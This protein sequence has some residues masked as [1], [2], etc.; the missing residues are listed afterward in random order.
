MPQSR[1]RRYLKHGM[2]PQLR[3]FEA[4][5]R[6]GSFTR[7]AEELHLAQ[8]T[9]SVQIRKLTETVGLPLLELVGKRVDLTAAG[10]ELYCACHK[11]YRT[12]E[13]LEEAFAQ[14]RGLQGGTLRIAS[15]GAGRRL[16]THLLAAFAETHPR[17]EVSLHVSCREG[18]LAR[19]AENA[20]DLYL[21]AHPPEGEPIVAQ[22][23]L[24]NPLLAF[25]RAD[26]ALAREQRIALAR[27]A[28]EP[29]LVR[30]PGS[31][32]R[33]VTE[34][35]FARHGL[36]PRIRMELCSDEAVV[37]AIFAGLGVSILSRHSL[38]RLNHRGRLA[39]L[40]VEGFPLESYWHLVYHAGKQL[41]FA[42][43][44]FFEFAREHARRLHDEL[45]D[46]L[47]D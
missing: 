25:G 18:L 10:R 37:E 5:A 6:H 44:A 41:S 22:R 14:L 35:L 40:S 4:I 47:A 11:I 24:P 33:L 13:E 27:F 12:L 38:W 28:E 8:P 9:V 26:H 2:L 39:S 43:R 29:L 1:I 46:A 31:G 42:A 16:A 19:L 32:T 30:E 3:V 23:L 45:K 34:R 20:D 36:T 15:S 7:A 17:I 21:L